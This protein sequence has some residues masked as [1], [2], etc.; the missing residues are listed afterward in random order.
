MLHTEIAARWAAVP[1]V[2][3]AATGAGL[4]PAVAEACRAHRAIAVSDAYRL[5]PWADVLYS[6]DARWWDFHTPSFAGEKWSSHEPGRNDKVDAARRHGLHLVRGSGGNIFRTDHQIAYG[7]NS[8]FQAINLAVLFGAR[9]IVLV[10]FNMS[11]PHF[12]GSH[13]RPLINSNPRSFVSAFAAA[14]ARMPAGLEIVNA[15]PGSAL[16]CWPQVDL[17]AVLAERAAA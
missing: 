10:G 3:V 2:V 11:G 15:T 5:M 7:S 12:F 16:R 1:V 9:R 14:A 17:A 8:G 4:T 6:C 13:P